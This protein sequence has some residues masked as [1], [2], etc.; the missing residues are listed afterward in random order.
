MK[1]KI[2]GIVRQIEAGDELSGSIINPH[3]LLFN[4]LKSLSLTHTLTHAHTQSR[5]ERGLAATL[6]SERSAKKSGFNDPF[7]VKGIRCIPEV[8]K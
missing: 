1:G 3:P 8:L 7:N 6:P 2:G 4:I 5:A